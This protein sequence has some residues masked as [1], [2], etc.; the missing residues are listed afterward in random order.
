M[1]VK[2]KAG[3]VSANYLKYNHAYL[4]RIKMFPIRLKKI[5]S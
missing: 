4:G 1:N 3:I 5:E 2:C